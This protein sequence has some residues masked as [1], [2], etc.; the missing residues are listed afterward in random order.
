MKHRIIT[1][2]NRT[3]QIIILAVSILFFFIFALFANSSTL[4]F[5][6][7]QSTPFLPAYVFVILVAY[8]LSRNNSIITIDQD[9]I[10][11]AGKD[12]NF[13]IPK[14]DVASIDMQTIAEGS[15]SSRVFLYLLSVK[16]KSG[17]INTIRFYGG[18]KK[19]LIIRDLVEHKY[20]SPAQADSFKGKSDLFSTIISFAVGFWAIIA[21]VDIFGLNIFKDFWNLFKSWFVF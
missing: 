1:K 6:F 21:F 15:Y 18:K 8:F 4:L 20:I 3:V 10:G 7:G 13:L 11:L 14:S 5:H 9:K 16:E 12:V 19:G 2:E 17:K